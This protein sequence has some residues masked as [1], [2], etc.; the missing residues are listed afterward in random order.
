MQIYKSGKE[1]DGTKKNSINIQKSNVNL[2]MQTS[3]LKM[4]DKPKFFETILGK[5]NKA[6]NIFRKNKRKNSKSSE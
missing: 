2:S 1:N 6:S 4:S 3:G 5:N